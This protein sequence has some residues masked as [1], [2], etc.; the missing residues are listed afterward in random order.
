MDPHLVVAIELQGEK[1]RR[2]RDSG[3][4]LDRR[5]RRAL[6]AA[7]EDQAPKPAGIFDQLMVG[8]MSGIM[9]KRRACII[10]ANAWVTSSTAR[11]R[12]LPGTR[13]GSRQGGSSRACSRY[14][15]GSADREAY[16]L[17]PPSSKVIQ[18]RPKIALFDHVNPQSATLRDTDRRS[19]ERS[20]VAEQDDVADRL[21]D[22]QR[23]EK[24]RPF[25]LAA[26]KNDCPW[27]TPEGTVAPAEIK[28]RWPRANNARLKGVEEPRRPPLQNPRARRSF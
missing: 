12:K 17:T 10:D 9:G 8:P 16:P 13:G 25:V 21:A 24:L 2:V 4:I 6:G 15:V 3:E 27:K 23:V 26:V 5:C 14:H 22:D 19:M 11:R 7:L 1:E 18:I 20:A 28:P